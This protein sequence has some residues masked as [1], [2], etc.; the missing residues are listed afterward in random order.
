MY[1]KIYEKISNF[2]LS[3]FRK[4]KK[5]QNLLSKLGIE[6]LYDLIYFFPRTYENKA[7]LKK[8]VNLLDGE[9]V[10]LIGK[11]TRIIMYGKMIK[12]YISDGEGIVELLWFNMPY[13]YKNIKEGDNILVNG[14]IKRNKFFQIINPKYTKI[15][16]NYNIN[17]LNNLD[18]LEPIYPL[19]K[20]I[21]QKDIINLVTESL[22]K[23]LFLF[24]E[25]L[26]K[27]YI[28][29]NKLLDRIEAITN[30]HFPKSKEKYEEAYR[31]IVYE[32]ALILEMK[33]LKNRY[34]EDI[35]NRHIYFLEDK[36]EFVKKYISNLS[37]ELTED[38]KK[39]IS[40]IYKELNKGKIINR[41]IQGD[42]GSGKTVIALILLL[43]MAENSY[44]GVIMAPT[45][46]LA[47]QHYLGIVEEFNKFNIK[48]ELLTSSIKG[49]KKEQ[50]YENIKSGKVDIV[51]GTHSLIDD[52]LEFKN[53]GLI[54]I[55]EQHKFGVEQ[56]NKIRNKGIYSNLIVM[57]ATPI[58]RS[59][60]LTIYGDLDISII[61]NLPKGRKEVKTKIINN[62]K[63]EEIMYKFI[64][65]KIKE[66][67]QVYV[68]S[69]LIENSEKLNL[70]SSEETFE[71]YKKKFSKYNV[72]LL[73]G[74]LKSKEKEKVMQEF[75]NNEID[76]LVSTSVVEVGVNVVNASIIVILSSE[77]F[78][79][80]SLHQL[81][82]R[83][84]RGNYSS[85]C[86]L[87][88]N[89]DNEIS[90]RRLEVMEETTDGFK[91][92]EED[93]KLRN[94]GEIFGMKQSGISDLKALDIVRDISIINLAK[95]YSIKYLEKNKGELYY[96]LLVDTNN[97]FKT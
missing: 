35:K 65:D 97:I 38:Q 56:R 86:F 82:G 8:M 9:N 28:I 79:L 70:A 43:Y 11:I 61:S 39:V 29:K 69:P 92:A 75:N 73:H 72:G 58:P 6:T 93:L 15:K 66:G 40:E 14:K 83:V 78:G 62:E 46:I 55:D 85:Y 49:K 34:S 19:V 68:V 59:L 44:Q 76:I 36:R 42:V 90:K 50:I 63:E 94:T 89:T 52:D 4:N 18:K 16:E 64:E 21:S 5:K 57:S 10:I 2:E 31:R 27:D 71:K 96:N 3:F 45:E 37:F 48:V 22:E 77:R 23:Y 91:I 25:N 51:I 88:S 81:R 30:L 32:E 67:R 26:P 41:L 74:K 53:L 1:S 84:G 13:I 20:G 54:V 80:S 12:A 47:K 17:E 95:N 87:V 60:A 33:I 7:K 24:E